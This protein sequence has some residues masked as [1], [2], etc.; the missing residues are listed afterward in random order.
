VTGP[1]TKRFNAT[2]VEFDAIREFIESA[3]ASMKPNERQR[4]VLLVEELFTN[5]VNHGYGGDSNQP[6]WLSL[7]VEG[8]DCQLVYEDSGPP[9]DP[10]SIPDKGASRGPAEERPVGGLGILLLIELSS[11]RRYERRGDRNVIELQVRRSL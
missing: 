3:C 6:V 11:N 1:T 7:N 2:H 9:H 8:E 4:V 10:F 5:T